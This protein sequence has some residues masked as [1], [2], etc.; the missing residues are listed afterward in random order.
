MYTPEQLRDIN[1]IRKITSGTHKEL[2]KFLHDHKCPIP[3]FGYPLMSFDPIGGTR[4]IDME[5]NTL[6]YDKEKH[7]FWIVLGDA[8]FKSAHFGNPLMIKNILESHETMEANY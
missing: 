3:I 5:N 1:V 2:S 7:S 8:V 6:I 4:E